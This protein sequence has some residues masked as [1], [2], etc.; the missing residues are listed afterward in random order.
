[1]PVGTQRFFD[2]WNKTKLSSRIYAT[3]GLVQPAGSILQTAPSI[4]SQAIIFPGTAG[5]KSSRYID[6]STFTRFVCTIQFWVTINKSGINQTIFDFAADGSTTSDLKLFI[7]TTNNVIL[8]RRGLSDIIIL[9]AAEYSSTVPIFLQFF[10]GNHSL[11]VKKNDITILSNYDWGYTSLSAFFSSV[12]TGAAEYFYL[13][14]S[15]N[16]TWYFTGAIESPRLFDGQARQTYVEQL[17]HKL[18]P[19]GFTVA[20]LREEPYLPQGAY[21]FPLDGSLA[22]YD[23]VTHQRTVQPGPTDNTVIFTDEGA[24]VGTAN[25]NLWPVKTGTKGFKVG[26]AGIKPPYGDTYIDITTATDSVS[27]SNYFSIAA[28]QWYTV[29]VYYRSTVPTPAGN[30]ANFRLVQSTGYSEIPRT[31]ESVKIASSKYERWERGFGTAYYTAATST[32]FPYI[33][34]PNTTRVCGV[35][36]ENRPFVSAYIDTTCPAGLLRFNLYNACGVRWNADYTIMYWKKMHGTYLNATSTGYNIESL[37]RNSN[38]VGGGHTWW[39]KDTAAN[40][41]ASSIGGNYATTTFTAWTAVQYQWMLVVIRHHNGVLT[42]QELHP[43]FT[44]TR[45]LTDNPGNIANFYVTQNGYD[46]QLGGLD[47]A[48]PVN[49]FYRDL[50]VIPGVAVADSF[51]DKYYKSKLIIQNNVVHTNFIQE[52][53]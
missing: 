17:Q 27:S 33:S 8:R 48:K 32:A 6:F 50:I 24:W 42:I 7:G 36:V 31:T 9:N 30:L 22:G 46:L 4:Q 51:I 39:G 23:P 29:S 5:I 44:Y 2:T 16:S 1:M 11:T 13:G 34:V 43:A 28:N 35:M 49:S 21:Y 53:V 3:D 37:G 10:F 14:M 26:T 18:T 45:S 15:A 52:G 47:N 40:T 19:T 12:H 38:T 20:S 41:W 25:T